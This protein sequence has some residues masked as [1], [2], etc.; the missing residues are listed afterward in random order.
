MSKHK[1]HHQRHVSPGQARR[2]QFIAPSPRRRLLSPTLVVSALCVVFAAILGYLVLSGRTPSAQPVTEIAGAGTDV[3]LPVSDFADG[4]ARFYRYT[5]VAGRQLRFFVMRSADG[6]IRS[7]FDAC[8]ICWT[9]R[10]G[11]HQEGDDMV[12]NNCRRRFPS[13]RLNVTQGGCNPGPLE[14]SVTGDRVTMSAAALD[15]GAGYFS[16]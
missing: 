7:A 5:T 1:K 13:T 4:A 2:D 15:S 9:K 16:F 8:D 3:S 6:V 14:R 11:Y 12:C 10:K